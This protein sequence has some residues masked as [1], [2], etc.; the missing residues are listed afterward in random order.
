[1]R[2]SQGK[3]RARFLWASGYNIFVNQS[4]HNLVLYLFM[5]TATLFNIY[6]WLINIDLMANSSITLAWMKL[7]WHVFQKAHHN[8]PSLDSI[9]ALWATISS[10]ITNK[11][12]EIW[13]WIDRE[14]DTCLHM[15]AERRRRSVALF[16]LS[17]ERACQATQ[18]FHCSARIWGW[19]KKFHE[20]WFWS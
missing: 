15:R 8:L 17:W 13:Y 3:C 1:M 18:V 9:L 4:V 2:G 10:E 19:L 6:C 5:F 16:D 12:W 11:M 20:Y 7:I 14:K